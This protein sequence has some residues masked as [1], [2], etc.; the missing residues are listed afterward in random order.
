MSK[1]YHIS[2]G[3][4]L[5]NKYFLIM[6]I[7]LFCDIKTI[8]SGLVRSFFEKLHALGKVLIGPFFLL[9]LTNSA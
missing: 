6:L 5:P 7:K 4:T 9:V 8:N 1:I 3:T 2:Q